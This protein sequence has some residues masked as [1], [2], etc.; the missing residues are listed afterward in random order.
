MAAGTGKGKI[1]LVDR[2]VIKRGAREDLRGALECTDRWAV[3]WY[4]F[5]NMEDGEE[6]CR[7]IEEWSNEGESLDDLSLKLVQNILRSN[8][9][10]GLKIC[11]K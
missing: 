6:G 2:E 10:K 9:K 7:K 8:S 11:R 1:V 5:V 3:D 4:A